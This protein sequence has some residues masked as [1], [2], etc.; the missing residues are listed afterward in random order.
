MTKIRKAIDRV[1]SAFTFISALLFFI[2]VIIVLT[3]ILGRA[4]FNRPVRGAIEIIQYG[5]L[6]CA[7][8]VMCRSGFDERH[9]CVTLVIDK[10]PGRGRAV[11]IALGKFVS[12]VVFA[13]ITY[14]FLQNIPEAIALNR[15]TDAFR[16][17]YHYIFIVLTFAFAMGAL[18]FFYQFCAAV[19]AV[20]G[21]APAKEDA[22]GPAG[23]DGP[24]DI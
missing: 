8:V 19:S 24:R 1:T 9:I 20:I 17:P 16:F 10:F 6:L 11:F 22:G 4:I 12:T 15:V 23:E 7:G 2:I 5:M 14:L 21:K 13:V 18:V 3:N